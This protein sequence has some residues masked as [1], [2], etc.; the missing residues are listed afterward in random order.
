MSNANS[1]AYMR[2]HSRAYML[3]EP[4]LANDICQA[5]T[6]KVI[7]KN[8]FRPHEIVVTRGRCPHL[9]YSVT[10]HRDGNG[11]LD[12]AVVDSTRRSATEFHNT[13]EAPK[14]S[15]HDQLLLSIV[16]KLQVSMENANAK[17]GNKFHSPGPQEEITI[18]Y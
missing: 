10:F 3:H 11:T 18:I 1:N 5:I 4:G 9:K 16:N 2:V 8:D 14:L 17:A 7:H 6:E 13:D 12:I 15:C